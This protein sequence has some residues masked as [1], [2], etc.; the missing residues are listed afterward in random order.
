MLFYSN[1]TIQHTQ[2]VKKAMRD[3]KDRC[4]LR[5]MSARMMDEYLGD[6]VG[7]VSVSNHHEN[8]TMVTD[9][10][11]HAE[12]HKS[13]PISSKRSMC[14]LEL[15]TKHKTFVALRNDLDSHIAWKFLRLHH[16]I[17]FSRNNFKVC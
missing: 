12:E 10:K 7:F 13:A 16:S 14:Y 8:L 4:H 2:H 15:D 3:V 9:M 11:A 6:K 17:V 5:G 1:S